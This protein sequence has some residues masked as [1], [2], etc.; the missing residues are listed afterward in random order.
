MV[1]ILNKAPWRPQSRGWSMLKGGMRSLLEKNYHSAKALYMYQLGQSQRKFKRTPILIYQMG[2]VGS[3]TIRSSLDDIVIDRP[4]YHCHFLTKERIAK[5][6]ADRKKFFRSERYSYLKRPWLNEFLAKQLKSGLKGRKWKVITLTREAVSRN[7]ST[8]FENLDFKV[9]D[10]GRRYEISSHYYK[11]APTIVEHNSHDVLI[12]LFF[13]KVNHDSP[14]QFFDFEIKR[15]LGVD[16]LASEFPKSKGYQI[17]KGDLAD[18]LLIR[19]EDLNRVASEAISEFLGIHRFRLLNSNIGT[20]KNYALVY[21][22]FKNIIAL[23]DDYLTRIYGSRYMRH[24]YTADEI[25][26]FERRWR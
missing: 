12:K 5:T 1:D 24:F 14:N 17:Y 2:K 15:M 8:F 25:E 10:E 22:N 7:L 21:K 9:I 18:V 19:L 23:P 13:E 4:I 16:V 3:S 20:K 26:T 11:I 6:E